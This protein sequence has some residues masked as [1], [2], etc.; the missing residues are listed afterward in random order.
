MKHT[1][2]FKIPPS[3]LYVNVILLTIGFG[4]GFATK[5]FIHPEQM[6]PPLQQP[7]QSTPLQHGPSVSV[8]FTPNKQCQS[9]IIA[10]INKAKNSIYVQAYSFTDR[11]IAQALVNAFKRGVKVRVLLDK[12]NRNDT[13][14]AKDILIHNKIPLRFDSP[15]GIAHNKVMVFDQTTALSGSYNFSANAFKRN[16]ENLIILNNKNLAQQ[17]IQ[18]WLK[19]WDISKETRSYKN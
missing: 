15:S 12:S 14:S 10:E 13:R 8:C 18:N 6:P 19:R 9:Q 16:T 2:K 17:Y 5:E 4:T 3:S 1:K 7:Y 11:D